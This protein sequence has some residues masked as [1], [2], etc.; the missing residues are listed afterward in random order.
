MK[1]KVYSIEGRRECYSVDQCLTLNTYTVGELITH[2]GWFEEDSSIVINNDEGYTYGS[3]S[4]SSFEEE[5]Y[6]DS[7]TT[8]LT[9]DGRR[10]GYSIEDVIRDTMTVGDLISQL[11]GYDEDMYVMLNNDNGYTYG[12]ID[13][14]SFEKEEYSTISAD[15]D[16]ILTAEEFADWHE[17]VYYREHKEIL[18]KIYNIL[19]EYSEEDDVEIQYDSCPLDVQEEITNL[20]KQTLKRR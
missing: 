15:D 19:D 16:E 10:D 4:Y 5:Y 20:V 6:E 3:I 7:E 18:D 13:D 1:H 11:E 2:L 9:I 8:V 14:R 12:S 17:N